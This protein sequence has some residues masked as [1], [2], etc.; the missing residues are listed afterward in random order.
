MGRRWN[1]HGMFLV[2]DIQEMKNLRII[3]QCDEM[4]FLKMNDVG[5]L[6]MSQNYG[7]KIPPKV[8]DHINSGERN[9]QAD[10][11]LIA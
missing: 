11:V 2:R 7:I 1:V 5:L 3:S 10:T 9:E 8:L 6:K 4:I